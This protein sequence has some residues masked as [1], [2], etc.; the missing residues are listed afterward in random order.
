[1]FGLKDEITGLAVRKPARLVSSSHAIKRGF[2]EV[3]CDGHHTHAGI[4]KLG[5]RENTV[6]SQPMQIWP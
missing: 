4:T 3:R 5:S 2:H 6:A 1:M